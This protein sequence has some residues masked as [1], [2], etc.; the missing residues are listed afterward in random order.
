MCD[1]ASIL[2]QNELLLKP[3]TLEPQ[4]L[5]H[6]EVRVRNLIATRVAMQ[7]AP[8]SCFEDYF[9]Q[10]GCLETGRGPDAVIIAVVPEIADPCR[11][12]VVITPRYQRRASETL[13][14]EES[15][16]EAVGQ[17]S[18]IELK[19]DQ[20]FQSDAE[21]ILTEATK[22]LTEAYAWLREQ[23]IQFI[24]DQSTVCMQSVMSQIRIA[25]D[26]EGKSNFLADLWPIWILPDQGIAVNLSDPEA[27]SR[28]I[29]RAGSAPA[30]SSISPAASVATFLGS[31][32]AFATTFSRQALAAGSRIDVCLSDAEY[33][34]HSYEFAASQERIFGTKNLSVQPIIGT[35]KL[36]LTAIY[37][38]AHV[39]D[40]EPIIVSL[41]SANQLIVQDQ[42]LRRERQFRGVTN[43]PVLRD[44]TAHAA[45]M[46]GEFLSPIVARILNLPY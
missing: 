44:A 23:L 25:F 12:V 20:R 3:S 46:A 33:L 32:I 24:K 2:Q 9:P 40:I 6:F 38:T 14:V 21:R 30:D 19:C 10:D 26:V 11:L 22:I 13:H 27:T 34:L 43:N 45:R 35:G 17:F 36:F 4:V 1:T 31:E 42:H 15:T 29:D 37:P 39:N 5:A 18:Q 41:A 16:V 8:S 7:L 28:I